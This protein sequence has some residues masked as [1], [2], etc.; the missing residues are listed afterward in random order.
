MLPVAFSALLKW[1]Y[2]FSSLICCHGENYIDWFLSFEPTLQLSGTI[3]NIIYYHFYIL[4]V[5]NSSHFIKNFC[6]YVH[7]GFVS[8]FLFFFF[9]M[10]VFGFCFRVMLAS[11]SKLKTVSCLSTFWKSFCRTAIISFLNA[12]RFAS[13][14]FFAWSFLRRKFFFPLWI[15]YI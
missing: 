15:K 11:Q 10:F 13:E 3:Y 5:L 4:L 6:I 7:N 14:G 8:S 12:G 2:D 9:V 1:Q